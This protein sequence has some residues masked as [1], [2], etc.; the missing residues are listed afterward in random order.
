MDQPK[1]IQKHFLQWILL[2]AWYTK[3]DN[4][5]FLVQEIEPLLIERIYKWIWSKLTDKQKQE[6][7]KMLDEKEDNEKISSYVQHC[8]PDYTTFIANIFEEFRKEYLAA[9]KED[10]S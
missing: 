2:E 7:E 10:V 5:D 9:M 1:D 4:L 8:I 6:I 3:E